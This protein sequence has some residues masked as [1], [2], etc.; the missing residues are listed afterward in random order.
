M[1][2]NPNHIRRR[3]VIS[4]DYHDKKVV[5]EF[6]TNNALRIYR[7][8]DRDDGVWLDNLEKQALAELLE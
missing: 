6:Y 4:E 2:A 3:E 1:P 7:G 5:V 8:E